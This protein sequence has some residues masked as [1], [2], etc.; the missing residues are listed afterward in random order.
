M[1]T[2]EWLIYLEQASALEGPHREFGR[3][4]TPGFHR[5]RSMNTDSQIEVYLQR[6]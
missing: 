5:D 1:T 6:R 2:A 3:C 4:R